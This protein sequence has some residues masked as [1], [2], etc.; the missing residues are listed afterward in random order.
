MIPLTRHAKRAAGPQSA[1][2]QGQTTQSDAGKEFTH[3]QRQELRLL[4]GCGTVP[5]IRNAFQKPKS[6]SESCGQML[7]VVRVEVRPATRLPYH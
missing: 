2:R 3:T 4:T 6:C 7:C 5:K 1:M